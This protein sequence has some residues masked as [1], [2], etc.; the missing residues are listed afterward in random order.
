MT[1]FGWEGGVIKELVTAITRLPSEL[2]KVKK[3]FHGDFIK[4]YCMEVF[5][6]S[7]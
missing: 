5:W 2:A 1:Y 4:S 6:Y 3:R 7:F